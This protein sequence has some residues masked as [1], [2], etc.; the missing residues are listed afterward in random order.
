MPI[1]ESDEEALEE[2]SKPYPELRVI[3]ADVTIL[4]FA[5]KGN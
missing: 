2:E 1:N 4:E 3:S 5:E